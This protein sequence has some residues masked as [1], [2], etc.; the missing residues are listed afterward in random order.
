MTIGDLLVSAA[1]AVPP[2]Y[3]WKSATPAP[4]V[5]S[6]AFAPLSSGAASLVEP[7]PDDDEPLSE[8]SSPHAA[9]PSASSPLITSAAADLRPT[10]R[11][12]VILPRRRAPPA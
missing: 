3:F 1:P 11:N 8:S 6:P 7:P 9:A 2:V 12:I 5:V 10:I 4:C